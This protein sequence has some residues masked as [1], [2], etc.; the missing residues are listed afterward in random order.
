MELLKKNIDNPTDLW[1]IVIDTEALIQDHFTQDDNL[2][3]ALKLFEKLEQNKFKNAWDC[4]KEF[5]EML[6]YNEELRDNTYNWESDLSADMILTVWVHQSYSR[7]VDVVWTHTYDQATIETRD[8]L[9]ENESMLQKFDA[10]PEEIKQLL[11][12]IPNLVTSCNVHCG[13]DIRAGYSGSILGYW[14]L[15]STIPLS[16]KI[17]WEFVGKDI[18]QYHF[19]NS[20]EAENKLEYFTRIDSEYG[21]EEETKL[22]WVDQE[23]CFEAMIS[24]DKGVLVPMFY[25]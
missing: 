22:A 10:M 16:I 5:M 18:D 14:D 7:S 25:P 4:E 20:Y 23:F 15:E 11:E 12:E 1:D 13:I 19:E 3:E 9:S 6:G 2:T 17:Q 8:Y 21:D 24:S